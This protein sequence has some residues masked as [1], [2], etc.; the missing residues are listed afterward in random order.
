MSQDLR[1]ALALLEKSGDLLRV[2]APLSWK[3][4]LAAALWECESGPTLLFENVVGYST[5]VVGNL[6]NRRDKLATALGLSAGDLQQHIVDGLRRPIAPTLVEEAPCFEVTVPPDTDLTDLL[7]VP[8]ISEHDGGR[9]LSAGVI[10][11]ED[12][13]TGRRN[14]AICRMQVQGPGRI[15]LFLA[16]THTRAVLEKHRSRGTTMQVAIALGLHPAIMVASQFLTPLDESHVA[17][18]LFGEPLE[19][20]HARTVDLDVPAYAEVILEGTLDPAETQLEGPF[21]EFPGTYAPQRPNPVLR[22]SAISTRRDPIFAMIVGG[23]HREHLVTGAI[24]REAGLFDAVQSVV[25][26]VTGVR[27][28]EGGTCRFHAVIAIRKQFEGEGRLAMLTAFTKQDLIKHVIVVDDDVDIHDPD[29]VEW[30]IATRS[31]AHEDFVT[32]PGMKSNPVDPMAI[33]KTVTK[34]G[35]DATL[36]IDAAPEARQRVGV[37]EHVAERVRGVMR[38][39]LA[40]AGS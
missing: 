11:S 27:L 14:L 13:D 16:P 3:F 28:P 9:Y 37:P 36:P 5:P 29:E 33:E 25:P 38:D 10:I 24:A 20:T 8:A 15:G 30:A 18:G 40:S 6:L 35:I 7:P 32:V 2:R 12:P 4:D 26:G 31:R 23:R 34:F 19:M 22:L 39:I 17:G 21:G 1:D